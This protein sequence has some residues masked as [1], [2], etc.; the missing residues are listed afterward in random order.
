MQ[1]L[2]PNICG[3]TKCRELE[4][5][6]FASDLLLTK[7]EQIKLTS[8]CP[9]YKLRARPLSLLSCLLFHLPTLP[10]VELPFQVVPRCPKFPTFKYIAFIQVID[11]PQSCLRQSPTLNLRLRTRKLET[12]TKNPLQPRFSPAIAEDCSTL[13]YWKALLQ[14]NA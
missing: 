14:K 4:H 10:G 7:S 12:G 11:D 5:C 8:Q 6:Y 1:A 9:N 13:W 2:L 3:L